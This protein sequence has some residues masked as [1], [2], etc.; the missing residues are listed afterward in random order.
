MLPSHCAGGSHR[1]CAPPLLP[2]A[3][4]PP[5]LFFRASVCTEL[6]CSLPLAWGAN[7]WSVDQ[8]VGLGR[9]LHL[10]V[11]SVQRPIN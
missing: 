4:L 3:S 11:S 7:R 6:S 5:A 1:G 10:K 8:G 2:P 9:T